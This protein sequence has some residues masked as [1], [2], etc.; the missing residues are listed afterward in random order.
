MLI[1]SWTGAVP[2]PLNEPVKPATVQTF[3]PQGNA[4]NVSLSQNN[5]LS[6]PYNETFTGGNLSVSPEWLPYSDLSHSFG[7]ESGNGWLGTHNGTQGIGRGGQLSL[8]SQQSI[9]SLTDF[10]TLV[11][12]AVGWRGTGLHHE[13]WGVTQP[14]SWTT[15]STHSLPSSAVDGQNVVGTVHP[16]DLQADMTGCLISPSFQIPGF[17]SNY[18]LSFDHWLALEDSDAAW[19]EWR[20]STL[21][22]WQTLAPV[23]GYTN[24]SGL[25]TTPSQV[26]SGQSNQWLS[27]EFSLDSYIPSGAETFEFRMCFQTSSDTSY[28]GGWF[29]DNMNLSNS[30][31]VP[32]VWFHGNQTGAYA[33][34]AYGRLRVEVDVSG[35][36]GPVE[37]E[38]W[39][40]W[41]LEG[42][43]NDNMQTFLSLDNGS[44]WQLISGLPGLPGNGFNWQGTYYMDE[45]NRWV[46]QMYSLPANV[47]T[48]ANASQAL[49]EFVVL[50]SSQVGF[51]GNGAS[52]W[53]GIMID[54]M[55]AYS[56]RG[57]A[58][59]QE[60]ALANFSQQPTAGQTGGNNGWL[61]PSTGD[62]NE[63]Q[64][65]NQY[66]MNGPT[67]D[68]DSF[69]STLTTP[70][71]WYV[72]GTGVQAWEIG[73][74]RNTSGY[75]PGSFHSGLNGAA[76]N[77][78]T[79]Y[80]PNI[81]THLISPEYVIPENATARLSFRSW[82]CTEANWDGGAVSISTDGGDSWWFIPVDTTSFH[83]Q[84]STPNTNS[85][86][87]GQGIL[88]GSNVAGG[89]GG[90]K[91]PRGFDLKTKDLSN[92][93]A[94]TVRAR[95]SFFSDTYIE[96]DGWYID[97]AG[98]EVD[99][100]ESE[101]VWTSPP[102]SPDPLYGYGLVD[103]WTD[104][105]NETEI[106]VDILDVQGDPIAGHQG[107]QFPIHLALD[108]LEFSSIHLRVRMSTQDVL[109]TPLIH[110]L[111][112]GTTV[113]IGPQYLQSL[114]AS[115]HQSNRTNNG[116]LQIN[117][118]LSID[119]P[120]TSVCPHSGYR[121]VSHGDNLSWIDTRVQ[122][123][124]S[125]YDGTDGGTNQLNMS[126][127]GLPELVH[128]I[129]VEASGG[130]VFRGATLRLDCV[131]APSA[132]RL[133][134]G[135]NA[136]E[137]WNW[138]EQG[139]SPTFGLNQQFHTATYD[140]QTWF[141][142]T[143]QPTPSL[144]VNNLPV[145]LNYTAV[146][147]ATNPI[148]SSAVTAMNILV[149]NTTGAV[150]LYVN[151]ALQ[152]TVTGPS[153]FVYTTNQTCP[154]QVIERPYATNANL[155]HCQVT[156]L[157][158]GEGDLKITDFHH[159][160]AAQTLDLNIP[161]VLLNQAKAASFDGDMRAVLDLPLHISTQ[162]GGLTIDMVAQT[163]PLMVESIDSLSHTR[164][165]PGESITI[166]SHHQRANPLNVLEDAPDFASVDLFLSPTARVEDAFLH[167]RVDR[168]ATTPRFLHLSGFGLAPID[169]TNSSV[170]C[171]LNSCTV[172]WSLT[173]TWLLDD[174]D[175]LHVLAYG[176]DS[177]GLETGPVISVRK[178]NF[179]E[180]E[181]D[182]EIIDFQVTDDLSRRLDDWTNPLW[183]FHLSDN[184][185]M[186]AEGRVRMEG[187]ANQWIEDGEAEI[188]INLHTVPPRNT[189]GGPDEWL[190]PVVNWSEQWSVEVGLDGRFSLPLISPDLSENLPSNTWLEVEPIISRTGPLGAAT[191]T[192][193]DRTV[194]LTPVRF[195]FD[196]MS[197][198][199]TSLTILDSGR[200][201]PADGHIWTSGQDVPLR[202]NLIDAEGVSSSLSVW[203][204][205]EARDDT[206]GNGE[207]EQSEYKQEN[208]S[209][210][211][212]RTELEV[213]LPLLSWSDAV[214]L[215]SDTGR[216]SVVLESEDLGGNSLEG[217]GDFG[218]D[219]DLATFIVQRRFD[220]IISSDNIWMDIENGTL[221][222]GKNHT[223]E[224]E[225]SDANGLDSLENIQFALLGR[226]RPADCNINYEPRFAV[227]GYDMTCFMSEP[228]VSIT[229]RPLAQ[230]FFVQFHFRLDWN[231]TFEFASGGWIPSLKVIDEG[232]DLGLGLSKINRLEWTPSNAVELR[233]LNITDMTQPIGSHNETTHWFHRNDRVHH[234]VGAFHLGTEYLTEYLPIQGQLTWELTDGERQEFGNITHSN[235]G[236][237]V[238]DVVLNENTM[239]R[240]HG[241]FN[242][243]VQGFEGYNISSLNYIVIVD[244][245][246][247]QLTLAPGS[248]QGIA[249]D[250]LEEIP[251]TVMISDDTNMPAGPI[252]LHHVFYRMGE[253]V[254]GTRGQIDVPLNITLNTKFIYE[255]TLNLKPTNIELQRSDLLVVWFEGA[256][257][258]GRPLVG[259]GTESDPFTVGITWVAF[260]PAFTGISALPFRPSVGE[261]ISVFIRVANE[262]LLDGDLTVTLRDDEG[263]LLQTESLYLTSGEWSNYVWEVEAWKTGR[264]GLTV[265]I[266]NVTPRIPVPLADIQEAT[267]DRADGE[268]GM[269]SLSM[270]SVVLAGLVLFVSRQRWSEREEDYQRAK[271][272]RIVFSSRPPPRPLE[273]LDI[274]R[275]E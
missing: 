270:L 176:K 33:A 96:A 93:S 217:G 265:E 263:T 125:H 51:G 227:I 157:L 64:W 167:V 193:E 54:D 120:S 18:T 208:I 253:E 134:L 3:L 60:R 144:H 76:I 40:N 44:T 79:S 237:F 225:I 178:T 155:S 207:I 189:S 72:E 187:I 1:T 39:A 130:E 271:I 119:L 259:L 184:R 204:W 36:N 135:Q 213:D 49:I 166:V 196:T 136:L 158:A 56:N 116:Y 228:T 244:D 214:G 15:N 4:T 151:G 199:V 99:V 102:L 28:R 24:T 147:P 53:E 95:F 206:N 69:E 140:Q 154:N 162:D 128:S 241:Q 45:S 143:T 32:G 203:T 38:F 183:P 252:V 26:W 2:H 232:N 198:T 238:F 195:L 220:T 153:N 160:Y 129:R 266:E 78:T 88:D 231:A 224:F 74:T 274:S 131:S 121:V 169:G 173:S 63:W 19:M 171:D 275:E 105:P 215:N 8:A 141:W 212:G 211:I 16:H 126:Y 188:Q 163:A 67:F 205:M 246:S 236:I 255:A 23:G 117:G 73:Q 233:W 97:D 242:V 273:L 20:T 194:I 209:M 149:T 70:S 182:M 229:Q 181:N 89:C 177:D 175:D 68:V 138:P 230:V 156:V 185:S 31:D 85:P 100:F 42:S 191:S 262:G 264:L 172:T 113:Y 210:N 87:F 107:L 159:M 124:S 111:T 35:M 114:S 258:S 219:G 223:F 108:P 234:E 118:T 110:S 94:M 168:L 27:S 186:I 17:V 71:G 190:G 104:I 5:A 216:V 14:G 43:F 11:E 81:Y 165:L 272:R 80:L 152:S 55:K 106:L 86:F 148:A 267:G 75:G 245:L 82:V 37:L 34:D 41:D 251:L 112:V 142:N 109:I 101:G 83:D 30:G 243:N 6:I 180:I 84:I 122:L 250:A 92:L 240:D 145:L 226:D 254:E 268:M 25:S 90:S 235:E 12:T 47:A 29:L 58:L 59:Q 249:S 66:G 174:V 261:N 115:Q 257:R 170:V 179:N 269:L 139:A 132:P 21:N 7:I 164:W 48:H 202:L 197:P 150:D 9:A 57:T 127:I 201:V 91:A 247:P 13:V 260:E 221:F 77:L 248:L 65:T 192:S 161:V 50:T 133:E 22:P 200:E 218:A 137:L 222:A 62:P 123:A 61:A 46:P 103:G 256:D 98:I 10:E 146:L 239:Y 52:G